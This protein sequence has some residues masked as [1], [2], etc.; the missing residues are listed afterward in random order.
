[1]R[2]RFL[3]VFLLSAIPTYFTPAVK[4]LAQEEID[5]EEAMRLED[6]GKVKT[7]L[8]MYEKLIN[9]PGETD[10]FRFYASLG[11]GRILSAGG[12]YQGAFDAFENGIRIAD[13]IGPDFIDGNNARYNLANLYTQFGKYDDAETLLNDAH[14]SK[15][16]EGSRKASALKAIVAARKGDNNRALA[17]I[18]SVMPEF[19]KADINRAVLLQNRAYI[20]RDL[21]RLKESEEDFQKAVSILSGTEKYVALSNLAMV[22]AELNKFDEAIN[23]INSVITYFRSQSGNVNEDLA[24]ALR[25]KGEILAKSGKQ[26]EAYKAFLEFFTLD[27]KTIIRNLPD[28]SPSTRLD[29][30]TKEK[31]SL[32]KIF[33]LGG[34][35][36]DFLSDVAIFRHQ[37][38]MMG[39]NDLDKLAENLSV[40]TKKIRQHLPDNG[41]ALQFV[42]HE[43]YPDSAVYVAILTPK[44]GKS[45]LIPVFP[46]AF[47]YSDEILKLYSLYSSVSG[48]NREALNHLYNSR[49]LAELV[50]K[51]VLDALPQG[52]TDIFFTPEGIFHLWA[53]ENMTYEPLSNIKLHRLSSM[54]SIEEINDRSGKAG[55]SLVI[56]GLDYS[57]EDPVE[58]ERDMVN[59]IDM[60]YAPSSEE[61]EYI[62]DRSAFRALW[63]YANLEEDANIFNYLP[64]TRAEAESIA[65]ILPRSDK[66]NVVSEETMKSEMGNFSTIHIATHGYCLDTG[67]AER[68]RML[69]D[70]VVIDRSLLY[71][72]IALSGANNGDKLPGDDGILSAREICNLNLNNADM[73]AL[74]ACQTAKGMI[75]DE[76]VSGLVR[77]IKMAGGGT[78]LASLWEVDDTSTRLFMEEFYRNISE[79]KSRREAFDSARSYLR[80]MTQSVSRRKFSPARLAGSREVSVKEVAPYKE[81]YYHSPFILID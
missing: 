42:E 12:N 78:I 59:M 45:S 1:M 35:Y 30:W 65:R 15:G 39:M 57:D 6:Q 32:S 20:L 38:S 23:N 41:V 43:A 58:T 2:F 16:T 48:E 51:P 19:G 40:D 69:E 9:D 11:K 24:I 53:I 80:S 62:P 70:S 74:S 8:Q 7:A 33:L 22:Q 68:P 3:Y 18:D 37:T 54:A 56:G 29:Y 28:L 79:G 50:W 63:E 44:S 73:I 72:G 21:R 66:R 67:L 10:F 26:D 77:A 49:Q 61:D 34:K 31:P 52:T 60:P 64:A 4:V 25:K 27:K 47:I 76:G 13:N 81:P 36:A 55:K 17:I 71:S 5:I 14:W 75:T 46:K